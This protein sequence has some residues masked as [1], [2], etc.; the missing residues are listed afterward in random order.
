[1]TTTH[2]QTKKSRGMLFSLMVGLGLLLQCGC[3]ALLIGGGAAAGAGGVAYV[4]GELKSKENAPLD[5]VW[6][7]TLGAMKEMEYPITSQT[8]DVLAAHSIARTAQDKKIDIT[9]K[10]LSDDST[11]VRIRVGTFGDQHL[12]QMILERI[13]KGTLTARR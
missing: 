11:E 8:K 7:A 9:L 5:R 10:K 3:A 12:S 1:M 2:L 13:Q 6:E 4:K